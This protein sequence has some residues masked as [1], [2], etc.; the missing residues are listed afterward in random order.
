MKINQ[1][2]IYQIQIS[3]IRK[4]GTW[5]LFILLANGGFAQRTGNIS[6]ERYYTIKQGNIW[7]HATRLMY[8]FRDGILYPQTETDT[9]Y[10][11]ND[12]E[13]EL[14]YRFDNLP[15]FLK[16]EMIPQKVAPKSEA[17][18]AV[19]YDTKV[20][21]T[22]GPTFDF[23][24]MQ[25]NDDKFAKKRLIVSP[26]IKEDFSKLT[27]EELKNAPEIT[28]DK[29]NYH[30]GTINMGDKITHTFSFTNTGKRDLI[31]RATKASCGC[32]SPEPKKKVISAGETGTIE[33]VFNSFGKHDK[34]DLRVTVIT[35][36]P[37]NPVSVLHLKGI[38]KTK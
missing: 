36:D 20:K 14:A 18:L 12:M 25:T 9:I 23:F 7:F 6:I 32:T 27:P 34:Q 24:Y 22:F 1:L 5:L 16:V 10:F 30:F 38:V 26:D 21:N 4:I 19:T 28:F 35:N 11:Y 3:M 17:K 37:T 15:E 8:G 13:H 31:I 33:V 2:I 29:M